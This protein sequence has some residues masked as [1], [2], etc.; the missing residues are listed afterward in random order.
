MVKKKNNG[1]IALMMGK[2]R[3][4][5][6]SDQM[7]VVVLSKNSK[8]RAISKNWSAIGISRKCSRKRVQY[9]RFGRT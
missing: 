5:N 8:T 9:S 7:E 6:N 3:T 2:E 1:S 4:V